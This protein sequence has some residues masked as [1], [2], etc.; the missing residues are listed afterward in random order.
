MKPEK[1]QELLQ[2]VE[3]FLADKY[4][5]SFHRVF[6]DDVKQAFPDIK[7]KH[8]KKMWKELK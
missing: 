6:F 1:Y 3:L 5:K 2:E 4:R 7:E 8:L